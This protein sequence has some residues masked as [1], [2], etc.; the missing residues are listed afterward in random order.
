M[1]D[2][3]V[4]PGVVVMA[5]GAWFDPPDANGEPER[6]GNPNGVLHGGAIELRNVV[7]L[8]RPVPR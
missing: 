7:S 1:I 8:R 5:T 4:M 3:D 6:H 2:P